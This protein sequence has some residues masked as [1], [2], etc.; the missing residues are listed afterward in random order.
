[1][2]GAIFDGNIESLGGAFGF[3]DGVNRGVAVS[4]ASITDALKSIYGN[5]VLVAELEAQ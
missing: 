4:T 1:V 3:D 2:I 5:R